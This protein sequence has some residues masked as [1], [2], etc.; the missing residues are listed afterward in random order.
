MV[1]GDE[2]QELGLDPIP[3]RVAHH[4]LLVGEEGLD[5]VVVHAAELLHVLRP[6]GGLVGRPSGVGS[7]AGQQGEHPPQQGLVLL[8]VLAEDPE[9]VVRVEVQR[10]DGVARRPGRR[11]RRPGSTTGPPRDDR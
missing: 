8:D 11:D 1:L 5:A 4:P 2:R 10:R 7:A 3:D 9:L 6:L